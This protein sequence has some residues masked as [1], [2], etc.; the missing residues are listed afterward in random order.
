[1][2]KKSIKKYNM[3]FIGENSTVAIRNSFE[4]FTLAKKWKK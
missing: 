4:E 3:E 1:M 2:H